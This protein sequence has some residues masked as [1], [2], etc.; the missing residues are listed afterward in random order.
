MQRKYKF[1]NCNT[2]F[3]ETELAE[4][5]DELYLPVIVIAELTYGFNLGT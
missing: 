1:R 4:F 5:G 3:M 2:L